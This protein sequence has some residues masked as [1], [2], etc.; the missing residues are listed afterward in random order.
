MLF[1]SS[2]SPVVEPFAPDSQG[3]LVTGIR[4]GDEAVQGHRDLEGQLSHRV[5][6]SVPVFAQGIESGTVWRR[7]SS[8]ETGMDG[9]HQPLAVRSSERAGAGVALYLKGELDLD[10][11][12]LMAA[13]LEQAMTTGDGEVFLDL[14]EC[15]FMDS[16]GLRTVIVAARRLWDRGETLR[17][18]GAHG[19]VQRLFELAALDKSP[20]F[21]FQDGEPFG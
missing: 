5:R 10:S 19:R 7:E 17:I 4:P 12:D 11:A 2:Q 3:M 6:P 9:R 20:L 13:E 14:S 15:T 21:S 16:T 18:C 8:D 1:R